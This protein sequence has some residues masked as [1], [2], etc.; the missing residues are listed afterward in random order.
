MCCFN[1]IV[2]HLSSYKAPLVESIGEDATQLVKRINHDP[3]TNRLVR[4]VLQCKC[5]TVSWQ[6]IL[7]AWKR[8]S[9]TAFLL[10]IYGSISKTMYLHF[11]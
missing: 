7:S 5:V 1:E 4:F 8:F 11:T 10:F 2:R 3:E 9:K 6:F